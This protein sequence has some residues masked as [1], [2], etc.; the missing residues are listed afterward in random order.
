VSPSLMIAERVSSQWLG[1]VGPTFLVGLPE[2]GSED[3]GY[4]QE[5]INV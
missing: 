3:T 4:E 2:H 5:A 1:S